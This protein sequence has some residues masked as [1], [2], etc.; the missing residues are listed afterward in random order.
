[1]KNKLHL[2][3]HEGGGRSNGRKDTYLLSIYSMYEIIGSKM[4]KQKMA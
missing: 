4:A 2:F 3:T 1:M